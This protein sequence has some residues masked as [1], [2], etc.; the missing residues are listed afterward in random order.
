[1][2]SALQTK[3]N[4]TKQVMEALKAQGVDV[5]ALLGGFFGAKGADKA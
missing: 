5:S 4:N 1:M 2:K 3:L